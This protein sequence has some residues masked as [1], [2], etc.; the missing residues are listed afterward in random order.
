MRCLPY[1]RPRVGFIERPLLLDPIEEIPPA[2]ILC[3]RGGGM[4]HRLLLGCVAAWRDARWAIGWVECER[5]HAVR[6]IEKHAV[7]KPCPI[8]QLRGVALELTSI[9]RKYLLFHL[10]HSKSST[11][12]GCCNR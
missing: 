2:K 4:I 1:E 3:V 8:P 12:P 10:K 9:T 5:R 11:T 7:T 6:R